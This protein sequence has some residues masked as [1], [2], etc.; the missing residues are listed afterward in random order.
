M[1]VAPS[2]I[3]EYV[4]TFRP[5]DKDYIVNLIVDGEAFTNAFEDQSTGVILDLMSEQCRD[6]LKSMLLLIRA[7]KYSDDE[8]IRKIRQ[9]CIGINKIWE[10]VS[11]WKN[12]LDVFDKHL[13]KL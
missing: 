7:G 9:H 13:K 2:K 8:E 10:T 11:K 5:V 1:D 3:R 6:E 12:K 4:E